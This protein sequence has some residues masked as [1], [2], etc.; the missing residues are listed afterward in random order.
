MGQV[1]LFGILRAKP[2]VW[3][4]GTEGPRNKILLPP[5]DRDPKV[6]ALSLGLGDRRSPNLTI[7]R[8][9]YEGGTPSY[10][11][12]HLLVALRGIEPRLPE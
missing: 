6:E 12:N 11:K 1:S 2:L 5:L 3:G 9:E 7:F 8:G 4:S 10:K